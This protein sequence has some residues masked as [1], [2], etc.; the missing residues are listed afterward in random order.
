MVKWYLVLIVSFFHI[1]GIYNS[2]YGSVVLLMVKVV[3]LPK[4]KALFDCDGSVP[5]SHTNDR[6][7]PL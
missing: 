6:Y 5:L 4:F 3:L 7:L 2:S 1:F